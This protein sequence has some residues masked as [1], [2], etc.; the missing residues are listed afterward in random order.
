[1]GEDVGELWGGFDPDD[2][3]L[4]LALDTDGLLSP[5]DALVLYA[6][7]DSGWTVPRPARGFVFRLLA[8]RRHGGCRVPCTSPVPAEW[9]DG[10]YVLAADSFEG[11]RVG[12]G[13]RPTPCSPPRGGLIL[14]DDD[15]D[16]PELCVSSASGGLWARLKRR[17]DF[18]NSIYTGEMREIRMDAL[19]DDCIEAGYS[20]EDC[21]ELTR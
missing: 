16:A 10:V 5:A 8:D 7:C 4:L 15:G 12:D 21:T 14:G 2:G 17:A 11:E 13:R 19:Y 6:D 20:I 9:S 18:I 3:A 1:M